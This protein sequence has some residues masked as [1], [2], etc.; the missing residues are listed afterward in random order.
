MTYLMLFTILAM[1]GGAASQPAASAGQADEC[2]DS[3]DCRQRTTD[4]LAH[5]EYETAHD[6]AWRAVQKGPKNDPELMLLLA[7]TQSLSG[8]PGD[9]IVML[10]R[11]AEAG[12]AVDVKDDPDF[13]RARDLSAWPAVAALLEAVETGETAESSEAP[14]APPA[15]ASAPSD[16]ATTPAP[17]SSKSDVLPAPPPT[18]VGVVS[19]A[20]R[21]MARRFAP[22]GLAYDAVSARFLFGDQHERKLIT[23]GDGFDHAVDFV[24]AESAGF[25]QVMSLGIDVP[26]GDLWVASVES[27]RGI[28]AVHKVQLISGRPLKT[29][30]ID[31][32]LQP[33]RLV[34]LAVTAAGAVLILDADGRRLLRVK[35]GAERVESIQK[36]AVDTPTS[37]AIGRAEQ[38]AYVAHES[39]VLR[40]DLRSRKA[41][42][43]EAAGDVEL[44]GFERI[45][46]HRGAL[47]GIQK[48]GDGS[49]RLVRLRLN[50]AGRAVTAAE[51]VQAS[52]PTGA[53]DG[54]VFA[55]I[56]GDQFSYIV[57]AGEAPSSEAT[58]QAE[59]IVY[60]VR[61]R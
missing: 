25:Y 17:S 11:L 24:R 15:P 61:L 22:G 52:L 45:R 35:P 58:D 26:R 28:G 18:R 23:A 3:Q 1:A 40:L 12:V 34:D 9:A 30:E 16:V 46:W 31:A 37:V 7:R 47:V 27:E 5:G 32:D 10:E 48:T 8:R 38:I 33:V 6:L 2:G 43:L 14:A 55:T 4:A 54:P 49:R 19:E 21:F 42:A 59:V 39:G 60:R 51:V 29:L 36:M 41:A 13:R 56:S 44:G 20:A 53:G 50:A 57:G